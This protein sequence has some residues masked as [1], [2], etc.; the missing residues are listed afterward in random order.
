MVDLTLQRGWTRIQASERG[1]LALVVLFALLIPFSTPR[2][3]A[4][5]EVQHYVYLRSLWFDGD[6]DFANDYR[7]FAELNPRSGIDRSLLQPDRI[8]QAT[9]L[10]GDIAPIGSA[11]M[12]APSFLLADG[13]VRLANAFGARIPADGFSAPYIYAVC[14]ASAL[15]GLLGLLL[16]YRLARRHAT[17][18][19]TALASATIWLA[20]PLVFYMFVLMP[21]AHATGFFLVAL[22]LTI[23]QETRGPHA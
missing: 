2:I 14:Y 6:F 9:G 18:F 20:T 10:Y 12:W 3:Y 1:L 21:W 4:T 13:V 23:W 17:P 15:Y 7:R 5:D 16:S 19:A 11:I 22:F 8:R